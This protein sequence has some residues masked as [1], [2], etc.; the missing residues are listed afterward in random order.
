[1]QWY[2]WIKVLH[3]LAV[4]SW[5]VGLLYLPRLFVYH[6]EIGLRSKEARIFEIME[7]RLLHGIM[8][9]AMIVA[10][11]SG[12]ALAYMGGFFSAGWFHGKFFLLI[13]L[14]AAHGFFARERRVIAESGQIRSSRFYR[15]ANE[16][17]TVLMVGIV[18]LVIVKPF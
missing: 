8:N 12:L 18:A 17:P 6:S 15:F 1:M 2:E 14:S 7:R 5:M 16:G 4:I 3:V 13:C 10:W 11:V 9:P